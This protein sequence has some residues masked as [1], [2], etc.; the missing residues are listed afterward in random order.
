MFTVFINEV[1]KMY[2]VERKVPAWSRRD[3]WEEAN[4]QV[5]EYLHVVINVTSPWNHVNVVT[6]IR[7]TQILGILCH[8]PSW[9]TDDWIRDEKLPQLKQLSSLSWD[10]G[11]ETL[12]IRIKQSS[13]LFDGTSLLV[14]RFN[15]TLN[16]GIPRR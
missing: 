16:T 11:I 2:W 8:P 6:G 4:L 1:G 15:Y 10:S 5:E 13:Q 3:T 14:K 9:A 12:V 7:T